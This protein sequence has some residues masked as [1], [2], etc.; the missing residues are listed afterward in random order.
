MNMTERH[1]RPEATWTAKIFYAAE[2]QPQCCWGRRGGGCVVAAC[3]VCSEIKKRGEEDG[4]KWCVVC[5]W[6]SG[7]VGLLYRISR[8][9][10]W[11][12]LKTV[13]ESERRPR[14]SIYLSRGNTLTSE[15]IA[16]TLGEGGYKSAI[17]PQAF[18]F[19]KR[20]KKRA[21]G[22]NVGQTFCLFYM[23]T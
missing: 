9:T 4:C 10:S 2:P 8:Q 19:R 23:M 12:N 21:T 6:R 3:Y 22:K 11:H 14:R 17:V 1:S 15:A 20:T 5:E 18:G 16:D 7:S 13:H